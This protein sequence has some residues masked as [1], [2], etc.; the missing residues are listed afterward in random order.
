MRIGRW[1][2]IQKPGTVTQAET[3]EINFFS[4]VHI[5]DIVSNIHCWRTM[6]KLYQEN[7]STLADGNSTLANVFENRLELAEQHCPA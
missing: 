2:Y 1:Q 5:K 6:L 7:V 3:K 4:S